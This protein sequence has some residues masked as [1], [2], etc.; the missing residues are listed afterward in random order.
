MSPLIDLLEQLLGPAKT[1][2]H[3]ELLFYCPFCPARHYKPKLAIRMSSGS[4]VYHCWIC[5]TKGR[6]L[7]HLFRKLNATPFQIEE[8]N[9]LTK[10][11]YFISDN[12]SDK[13]PLSLPPE[14]IPL[15]IPNSMPEYKH[16]MLYA[17]RRGISVEDIMKYMIGY[18]DSGTYRNMLIIPSY[19]KD[20][21]LNYFV[22]RSFYNDSVIKYKNPP[23]SKDVIGFEF[24]LSYLL[25]LII[26]EG[27][28]DA[29]NIKRNTIPLFGKTLSGKLKSRLVK[30]DIS[31]IYFALDR[32]AM[33][34][35]VKIAEEFMG[36][37]KQVYIVDMPEKDPADLGFEKFTAL[38]NKTEPLTFSKLMR[39]KMGV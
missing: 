29:I 36:L 26:C 22:G 28:L 25:P 7:Y 12:V 33:S 16:A 11:D 2:A 32:D 31:D 39:H 10:S 24:F 18:A 4:A 35:V 8:L 6:S 15:W 30:R 20:G 27:P 21:K 19:D 34:E 38:M 9:R 17:K 3:N 5:E 23:V 13:Q 1:L 14:F 37:G